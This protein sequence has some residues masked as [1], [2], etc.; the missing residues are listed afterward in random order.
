M[1]RQIHGGV[2][3]VIRANNIFFKIPVQFH[4]FVI[5]FNVPAISPLLNSM[6]MHRKRRLTLNIPDIIYCGVIEIRNYGL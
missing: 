4:W 1:S 3:D 2:E 5:K 6:A